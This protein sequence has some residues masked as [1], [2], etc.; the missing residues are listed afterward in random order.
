MGS[1]AEKD[2]PKTKKAKSYRETRGSF[3]GQAEVSRTQWQMGPIKH[4][5]MT[6]TL[7][8]R[9]ERMQQKPAKPKHRWRL[10]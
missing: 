1:G 7:G 3:E 10:E 2:D 4:I 9:L 5:D 8:W 6:I